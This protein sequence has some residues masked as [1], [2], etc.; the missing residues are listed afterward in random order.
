MPHITDSEKF[1]RLAFPLFNL[2]R[3]N[4]VELTFLTPSP[5]PYSEVSFFSWL[6]PVFVPRRVEP[7]TQSLSAALYTR[8]PMRIGQA[9][10]HFLVR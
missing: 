10:E 5:L 1:N 7:L 3:C 8:I 6:S 4:P 9:L 2:F